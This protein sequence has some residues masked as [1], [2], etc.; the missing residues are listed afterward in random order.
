[1][2]FSL[3]AAAL[4]VLLAGPASA[5]KGDACVKAGE[6]KTK[7]AILAAV[8]KD[9]KEWADALQKRGLYLAPGGSWMQRY[10]GGEATAGNAAFAATFGDYCSAK[11]VQASQAAARSAAKEREAAIRAE[12]Q[13]DLARRQAEY[14]KTSTDEARRRVETIR[15]KAN[16]MAGQEAVAVQAAAPPS[17][18]AAGANCPALCGPVQTCRD[19][20]VSGGG[21]DNVGCNIAYAKARA[22]S[23]SCQ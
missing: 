13:A 3:P 5:D 22:S 11:A 2:R 12:A 21:S 14:D 20:G 16:A 7:D 15:R 1:M 18:S 8:P 4:A 17:A 23:C 19:A 6:L 10:R 9:D